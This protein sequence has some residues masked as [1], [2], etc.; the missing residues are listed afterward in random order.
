MRGPLSIRS[1]SRGAGLGVGAATALA[2]PLMEITVLHA[3]F[4]V[5]LSEETLV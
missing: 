5:F 3:Y 1:R 4:N 2:A